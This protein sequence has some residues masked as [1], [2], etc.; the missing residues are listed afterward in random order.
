MTD[1]AITLDGMVPDSLRPTSARILLDSL[2]VQADIGFHD[3][4]IGTP[5]RL[6]VTV[7]IWLDHVPPADCD[8][9]A[10]A[11]NYDY[12]RTQVEELAAARRY[13]LQESLAH[14]IYQRI[15]AMRG[16]K[17]LRVVTSK[18][19]IYPNAKGVGVEIAS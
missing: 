7:E 15:A 4:E 17:K 12:L 8:D 19:D 10:R 3:Y 13:N 14:A 16:V 9:P 6:I 18:P 1:H 11:W 5:Q 2:E